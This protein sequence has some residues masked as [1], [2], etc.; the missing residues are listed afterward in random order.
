[1]I[2]SSLLPE[3]DFCQNSGFHTLRFCI[4]CIFA[5]SNTL[6]SQPIIQRNM[7]NTHTTDS[8]ELTNG[9]F[10]ALFLILMIIL[11]VFGDL[12]VFIVGL[13]SLST[14]FASYFSGKPSG[15]DHH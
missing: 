13:I 1:M 9:F 5:F 6:L 10:I 12:F 3:K 8:P 2:A 11:G 15:D 7:E 14:M 4:F